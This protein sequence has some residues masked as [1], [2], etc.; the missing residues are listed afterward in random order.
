[1]GE[2]T[3][4]LTIHLIVAWIDFLIIFKASIG[5]KDHTIVWKNCY[6]R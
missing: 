1:M 6:E 4:L 5:L 3:K 2:N